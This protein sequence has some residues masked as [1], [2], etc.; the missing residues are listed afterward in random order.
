M[1]FAS[2]LFLLAVT[3]VNVTTNAVTS[4]DTFATASVTRRVRDV[5]IRHGWQARLAALEQIQ[6]R[7]LNESTTDFLDYLNPSTIGPLLCSLLGMMDGI[8]EDL[9]GVNLSCNFSCDDTSENVQVKC[10]MP[11]LLCEPDGEFCVIDTAFD[12]TMSTN[13]DNIIMD[14]CMKYDTVPVGYEELA[15]KTFCAVVETEIDLQSLGDMSDLE[16]I[17]NANADE[18]ILTDVVQIEKCS[19]TLT[20][21]V[22]TCNICNGAMGIQIECSN[23]FGSEWCNDVNMSELSEV[24]SIASGSF[25]AV[26]AVGNSLSLVRLTKEVESAAA[27]FLS[28]IAT[29]WVTILTFASLLL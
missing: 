29:T 12:M 16:E 11:D 1:H 14:T 13:L 19:V 20:D 2:T 6:S 3:A 7:S 5:A 21:V 17:M 15:G 24:T 26:D 28:S 25:S 23:G 27:G 4:V 10:T 8:D 18:G 22:C 9:E